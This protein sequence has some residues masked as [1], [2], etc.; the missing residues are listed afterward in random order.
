MRKI[1]QRSS[2]FAFGT[3]L[4]LGLCGC[5]NTV[6]VH[7]DEVATC[8]VF[9]TNPGGS[10]HTTTGAAGLFVIY[11]ITEF[12][13]TGS[14]AKA[15]HFE[16]TKVFTGSNHDHAN[17]FQFDYLLTKLAQPKT[18]AKGTTAHDLGLLFI[19]VSSAD[20]KTDKNVDFF[21]G[22]DSTGS[23]SMLLTRDNLHALPAFQDPCSPASINGL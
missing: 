9:D 15:F 1:T 20:P 6:N 21:L 19:D 11:K 4:A 23:E 18:V 2:F 3:V 13:N 16:P 12:E 22:Y 10:P 5:A 7:Y 14:A 17:S 8:A